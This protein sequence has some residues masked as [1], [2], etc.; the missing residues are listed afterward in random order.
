MNEDAKNGHDLKYDDLCR[1]HWEQSTDLDLTDLSDTQKIIGSFQRVF[2]RLLVLL[3]F[4]IFVLFKS[5]YVMWFPTHSYFLSYT[6][7]CGET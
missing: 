7:I 2:H 1:H 4:L 6:H 3:L 5:V